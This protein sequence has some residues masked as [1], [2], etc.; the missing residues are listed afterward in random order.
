MSNTWPPQ[1]GYTGYIYRSEV[2]PFQPGPSGQTTV[3]LNQLAAEGWRLVGSHLVP[4]TH[5]SRLDPQAQQGL[6]L[7]VIL[8]RREG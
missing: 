1:A 5:G 4:V 3:T 7:L 6:G 8:E 2:I